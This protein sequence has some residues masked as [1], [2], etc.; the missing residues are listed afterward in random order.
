[1]DANSILHVTA[2]DKETGNEKQVTISSNSRLSESEIQQMLREAEE[3]AEEDRIIKERVVASN[4]LESL[5]SSVRQ[6]VENLEGEEREEVEKVVREGEAWVENNK[7]APKDELEE[8]IKEIENSVMPYW[9]KMK[10][11]NQQTGEEM[12]Q[13]D[14]M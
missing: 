13:H 1:M 11:G 4:N 14:D 9:Q 7:E 8:K 12:P 10:G 5:I 3:A 6:N 2:K